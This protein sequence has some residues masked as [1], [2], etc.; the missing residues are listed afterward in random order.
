MKNY[1]LVY[2]LR[3]S[4]NITVGL[5]KRNFGVHKEITFNLIPMNFYVIINLT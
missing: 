2:F 5:E 4:F 3:Q 1:K